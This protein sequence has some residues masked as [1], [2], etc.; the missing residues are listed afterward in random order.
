MDIFSAIAFL[1]GLAFFLYGMSML[2]DGL[3]RA[4]GGKMEKI[5][6]K[7]TNSRFKAVLLGAGVT[8]VIQSSSATTVMVV[9]FVN[10]GIMK[11]TQAVGLIMGANIGTTAT[12]WILSLTGIQGNNIWLRMLKPTSFAPILAIIGAFVL[13]L[14]KNEKKKNVATIMVGFAILMSG[15]TAMSSAVE[16]LAE[17]PEFGEI[18]VKFANPV[19][20]V[21]AGMIITA[22]IQSS[23]ASVGILQA[24][25]ATGTVTYGLAIPIIMGQNIGTCITAIMSAIGASKNAKRAAAI[26]LYFNMIGTIVCLVLFYGINAFVRFDFLTD[27]IGPANI[28]VIHSVFNIFT[29]ALLLPFGDQLVKLAQLTVGK[30]RENRRN[31]DSG[32]GRTFPGTSGTGSRIFLCG[33]KTNGVSVQRISVIRTGSV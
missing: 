6:E 1:G 12:S 2:G 25:C 18:L 3:S 32:T 8:A 4:S 15:M 16:P 28:A 9:G 19:A 17:V 27:A 10:A 31:A 24:L 33:S 23:S 5:L 20:G 7:L 22:V 11:L 29:T 21:L 14:S 30:H 26:H 13:M